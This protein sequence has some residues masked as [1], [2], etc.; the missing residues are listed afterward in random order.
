[1]VKFV[2][3]LTLLALV[4]RENAF[5]SRV[6]EVHPE[7][8]HHVITTGP[9]ATVRHPMYAGYIVWLLA[10]PVALGSVPALVPAGL[11]AAGIVVRTVLED[12]TL[13]TELPGYPEYALKVRWRLLP[14]VF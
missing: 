6:V 14:R 7:A 8:G 5:L 4:L 13:H 10:T 2:F 9:Y 12:R 3:A 1:M 11:V